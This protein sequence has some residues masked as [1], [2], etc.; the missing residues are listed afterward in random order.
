MIKWVGALIPPPHVAYAVVVVGQC[1]G[2]AGQPLL[3][4][5]AAR[6][7]AEWF[8]EHE[9]DIATTCA[10]MSNILG[11]MVASF[12]PAL[13][14]TT[15]DQLPVVLVY[16][17]YLFAILLTV[18]LA[19]LE[20]RPRAPP[21]PAAALQWY[22]REG[23]L[24][25]AA[26]TKRDLSAAALEAAARE[27]RAVLQNGNFLLL[28]M[29]FAIGTGTV[30]AVLILE[31]QIIAPCGYSDEFAGVAG[32]SMLA[33]GVTVAFVVAF[34]MEATKAY[35]E[36]QK[37][38]ALCVLA[39]VAGVFFVNQPDNRL[40]ILVAWC[41][42]GAAVQPLMP[43]TLEHAS[44]M[45]YP[46]S[47]DASTS[48]LLARRPPPPPPRAIRRSSPLGA[49]VTRGRPPAPPPPPHRRRR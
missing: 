8:P 34:I 10:T 31:Q 38:D 7:S 48:V 32:A 19:F 41:L 9:R 36:I 27:V 25:D 33:T 28:L 29:G 39:A 3:L 5:V 16:Q 49:C 1:V 47:A 22:L 2:A 12:T 23:A 35:V 40:G 18:A 37:V 46:A 11:Q 44:E 20:E 17:V 26:A 13:L 6:L 15:V 4:N 30:W 45:T 21:S 43:I 14:V 42:L 24:A